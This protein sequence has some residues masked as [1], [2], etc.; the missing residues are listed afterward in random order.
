MA[1]VRRR[2]L[3]RSVRLWVTRRPDGAH[4]SVPPW[5]WWAPTHPVGWAATTHA[6]R[7]AEIV[8]LFAH[9]A[10]AH[11]RRLRSTSPGQAS[12]WLHSLNR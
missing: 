12:S 4:R 10:L 3:A 5:R 9:P 8:E 1:V 11:T 2:V 7:H 6:A